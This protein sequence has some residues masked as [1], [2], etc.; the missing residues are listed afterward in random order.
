[1][2]KTYSWVGKEVKIPR[3]LT[4]S[5]QDLKM[6]L[7]MQRTAEQIKQSL[8]QEGF[9]LEEMHRNPLILRTTTT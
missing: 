7:T 3:K 9:D 1:M 2:P 4:N 8:V 5:P 6:R